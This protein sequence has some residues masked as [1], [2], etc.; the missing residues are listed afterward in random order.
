M[1][2]VNV[3]ISAMVCNVIGLN[4]EKRKR[5][6]VSHHNLNNSQ[7]HVIKLILLR[8]DHCHTSTVHWHRTF[9]TVKFHSYQHY[10]N[11]LSQMCYNVSYFTSNEN[12]RFIV[13]KNLFGAQQG[14]YSEES[15]HVCILL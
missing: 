12:E 2:A 10:Q 9:S 6:D 8:S 13:E 5:P 3:V 14:S 11:M 15:L 7:L 1:R 4:N